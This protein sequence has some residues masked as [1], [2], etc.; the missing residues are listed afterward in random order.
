MGKE[1]VIEALDYGLVV[2]DSQKFTEN[3]VYI[4]GSVGQSGHCSLVIVFMAVDGG[5]SGLSEVVMH[6]P[7]GVMKLEDTHFA[8]RKGLEK[9]Y[10]HF[11]VNCSFLDEEDIN[12]IIYK[13]DALWI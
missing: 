12:T 1:T 5:I 7:H 4:L 13:W 3:E 10:S 9:I 2:K 8:I 11:I 6:I